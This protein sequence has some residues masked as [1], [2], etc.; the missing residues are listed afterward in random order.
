M[1][2]A[3]PIGIGGVIIAALVYI[4]FQ[5]AGNVSKSVVRQQAEV[6]I[7]PTVV[8]L[9]TT[10]MPSTAQVSALV[11]GITLSISSPANNST[12][13]SSSVIVRGKTVA[14]AD[15]FVNDAETK[16]DGSGS[17]SVTLTLDEGENYILVVANDANGNYSEKD[18][19]VTYTP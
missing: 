16:S 19:T 11:T 13:A 17:F 5:S 3:V 14:N 7:E 1:N 10:V 4:S 12:V 2:K 8:S 18:L 6:T 15:V 9:E